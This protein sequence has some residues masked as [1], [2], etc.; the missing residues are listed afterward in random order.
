MTGLNLFKHTQRQASA[1]RPRQS[2]C[3]SWHK[4]EPPDLRGGLIVVGL[5][6]VLGLGYLLQ[7]LSGHEGEGVFVFLFA[8]VLLLVGSLLL[9]VAVGQHLASRFSGI[10]KRCGCCRFFEV[11]SGLYV[12]GRCQANPSRTLVTRSDVCP[13]FFFSERALAR[14]RLGQQPG[15]LRQLHIRPTSDTANKS[16]G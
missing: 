6:A 14:D 13:S 15:V 11:P 16:P 7:S 4:P 2:S 1:P 12:I 8:C 5:G 10:K 3:R 9:L